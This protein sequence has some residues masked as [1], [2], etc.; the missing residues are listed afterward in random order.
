[1]SAT[2]QFTTFSDLYNGVLKAVRSS[3]SQSSTIELAKQA[4]NLGLQD[5]HLGTEYQFYWAEREATLLTVPPYTTGTVALTQ[6]S[7]TVTGTDTLWNTANWT[8]NANVVAGMK[9]KFPGSQTVY[10]VSAVA[11]DTSLT[12]TAIYDGADVTGATYSAFGDTYSMASDYLRPV[13]MQFF[14]ANREIRLVDRRQLRR[15]M[16]QRYIT[17]Y[18]EWA[19]QVELGPSGSTALRPRLVFLPPPDAVYRIPYAYITN[20]LAVASDGT[21]AVSLSS[22]TDEPI[23][24]L[25]YRHAIYYYALMKVYEGK[26]D[27]RYTTAK[28]MYTETMM[29][30]LS[31]VTVGDRRARIEPNVT[32]YARQAQRPY[33]GRGSGHRFDFHNRFDH[34]G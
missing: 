14:D 28:Q 2:T 6:G 20:L 24:P 16:P 23:V 26:D 32:A 33:S 10:E 31:D 1:M 11:S 30:T 29:R 34:L 22:D 19:T 25:R 18:P 27:A 15:A 12:L 9:I 17:G 4:V 21:L 3:Q 7:A 8:G 5:M 13:D